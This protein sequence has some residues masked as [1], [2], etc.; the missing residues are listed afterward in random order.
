MLNLTS[1]LLL[2]QMA[3]GKRDLA[4]ALHLFRRDL[5][6][7]TPHR[8]TRP[9]ERLPVPTSI[10]GFKHDL[11][12]RVRGGAERAIKERNRVAYD[13]A[14]EWLLTDADGLVAYLRGDVD[15]PAE[16]VD[17]LPTP[18]ERSL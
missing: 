7:S 4:Q 11:L 14:R 9:I 5:A 2:V 12:G 1:L 15:A 17:R 13:L 6:V 3:L 8:L 10:R 16:W 18:S